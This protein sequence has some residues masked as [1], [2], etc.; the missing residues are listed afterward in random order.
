MANA[1]EK[2]ES[3][4]NFP[5][6]W[7]RYTCTKLIGKGGMGEIFLADD[8]ICDRSIALKRIQKKMLENATLRKRFLAEARI[9]AQLPHPSIIP[10]YELV[11][12]KD[13]IY[14][15]MPY[16]EG[17]TLAEILVKTRLSIEHELPPYPRGSSIQTLMIMFLNL[18]NAIEFTHS[19][20]FLHR[21]IKPSNIII[22]D[23]N[24]LVILDW[25]VATKMENIEQVEKEESQLKEFEEEVPKL[26]GLTL[27]GRAVGT[28]EFMAP[29]RVLK[30]PASALT[31]IYS[32][33][34]TLH[35]M[36]TLQT[37]FKRPHQIKEFRKIIYERGPEKLIDPQ[38]I[39]PHR[40]ITPQLSRIV[41]KCLDPD[42]TKRYQTV[43]ELITDVQRY[44]QGQPE[45]I[46]VTD[47]KINKKDDWE[48]QEHVPLT[49]HMAIS[50]YTGVMEWAMVMLSKEFYA[51]NIQI[52]TKVKL[53]KSSV[54]LGLL[55]CVPD[56]SGKHGPE[57]GYLV[58]IG[59]KDHPGCKFLHSNVEVTH[60][61]QLYLEPDRTYTLSMERQDNVF[62]FSIDE[63]ATL[64]HI[65]HVPIAGGH[66]GLVLRDGDLDIDPLTLLTG[67]Q[68]VYI[69]CLSIPDALFLSK[70]YV[71]ALTEYRRISHSFKGRAEGRDAIFR[72]G[73]TL[74]EQGKAS[75]T[76]REK[77][78]AEAEKEFARLHNTPGAPVEYLG[79][80]LVYQAE[81][82]LKEETK[83][84]ELALRMYP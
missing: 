14:Y 45:W 35:F 52:K 57:K 82:E 41:L 70:Y 68:N 15:T 54:G 77:L 34:G 43:K 16:V 36:L 76:K 2:Q 3:E 26:G 7:G 59:S 58:W 51:G 83:A 23:Y 74:I 53:K 56:A 47:F 67:S 46:P 1:N 31:D 60:L 8:P 64:S 17:K 39:A 61:E 72:A 69:N 80:S 75:T 9:A 84:L 37:P 42:P 33:G 32:L 81:G 40:E 24:D 49:K 20:G 4:Y 65:S 19:K 21:D 50:R 5:F 25:G 10:V 66:F 12:E 22:G 18:C 71:R 6:K 13:T 62:R 48:F 38:E 27:P 44:I 79:K 55:M 30:V 28:V 73:L 11:E 29:E 63:Q 78:F